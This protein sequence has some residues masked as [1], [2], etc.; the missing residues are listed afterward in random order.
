VA[1]RSPLE[2]AVQRSGGLGYAIAAS[3]VVLTILWP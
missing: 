3:V 1:K 2:M